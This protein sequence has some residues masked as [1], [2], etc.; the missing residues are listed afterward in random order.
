[1][2]KESEKEQI[3]VCNWIPL[4]YTWNQLNIVNQLH[5]NKSKRKKQNDMGPAKIESL[6]AKKEVRGKKEEEE[7]SWW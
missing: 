2:R 6:I 1:M 4:L 5:S 3:N 7:A